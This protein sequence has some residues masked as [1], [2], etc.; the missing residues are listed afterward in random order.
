MRQDEP[1]GGRRWM[2]SQ[3]DEMPRDRSDVEP[4]MELDQGQNEDVEGPRAASPPTA[5]WQ[6]IKSRF[7]DDP[8]GALTAAE[9]LVRSAVDE[10]VRRLQQGFEE[11]RASERTEGSSA[12]EKLR[13]R[14]IRY[15][16][17]YESIRGP[18]VH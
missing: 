14:L 18:A 10:R 6:E 16:A 11:L 1:T 8:E 3:R 2:T 17:Y 7:V 4:A 12:T 13:L 5:T 15:Q 9:G